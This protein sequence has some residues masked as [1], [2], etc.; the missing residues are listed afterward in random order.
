ML[1]N[2]LSNEKCH[3]AGDETS[4]PVARCSRSVGPVVR[5]K[6]RLRTSRARDS[7]GL[8]ARGLDGVPHYPLKPHACWFIVREVTFAG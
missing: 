3:M 5:K 1:I 4:A 2:Y 8:R 7:V 6:M